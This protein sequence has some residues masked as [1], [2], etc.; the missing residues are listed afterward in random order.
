MIRTGKLS[1]SLRTTAAALL[2]VACS[3][4]APASGPGRA[5]DDRAQPRV[6]AD[7]SLADQ[8]ASLAERGKFGELAR[9][10]EGLPQTPE[11]KSL[12][13]SIALY[14]EHLQ[15][16]REAKQ[17]AYDEAL[18]EAMTHLDE[19]KV[20]DAMAKVIEAHSLSD[21]PDKL[22]EKPR[23][24]ELIRAVVAKAEKAHEE[25]RF[26]DSV[27]LYRLL[28]LLYEDSRK[29]HQEYLDAVTH[30][31]VLQLY[32]PAGLRELYKERAERL[33]D[34]DTLELFAEADDQELEDWT[35][36][37]EGIELTMI[38]QVFTQAATRHI[39]KD[40]Y[41]T[42]LRGAADGLSMMIQT[43][44]IESVFPGLKDE[45][46]VDKLQAKLDEVIED[47]DRPGR[48]L[49]RTS[50]MTTLVEIMEVNR[51]SVGLPENVIVYELTT[52]ATNQLDQFSAVIWPEELRQFTRSI[53]GNF[54]GVGVQIQK[55]DGK[56]TVVTPL[57]G[58]PA[59]KAGLKANDIIAR[60]NG[61]A[62]G[63]WSIDKAV[64]EITGPENTK[65]TLTIIREG[66]ED[67]FNVEITRK[68]IDLE[69]IKG[70]AHRDEGGW[71]YWVDKQAGIGYIRMTQFLRQ[72]ADDMDKAV[73]QMQKE[74]DLN[75]IVLDLRFNPG[76]LLSTAIGVVDRFIDDGRIVATVNAEG[77]A[78]SSH[79]ASRNKT[80]DADIDLVI[81]INQGSASASEIVSG[82]LQDYE[83]AIVLGENTYGKGSVQDIFPIGNNEAFFK[84]TTQYYQLPKGR[85]IH[86]KDDSK[87]WGIQ[88]DLE[89][90]MTNQE[91][92]DWLEA[93]RDADV[94]I[95]KEDRDPD[96]PQVNPRE[97][98]EQGL[99]PQLE[100]AVLLLKARQ[101]A[102]KTELA[103]RG[104]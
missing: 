48:R 60:V 30:V 49:T 69:S 81:L 27:S 18:A 59:M 68:Q 96:N 56:L 32:D 17:K 54:V 12:T 20:E 57:E 66:V 97:S 16:R 103:R 4:T 73:A 34:E 26:V 104:E 39:D 42:L 82:A 38:A 85:I 52:G 92:I 87:E 62:T 45:T 95:A 24:A 89:V 47:L 19:G 22:L 75:G 86:R 44:G 76:G 78:T 33:G 5:A 79:G 46:K 77:I 55:T 21:H 61:V 84:C 40:G 90:K 102:S 58:T 28:D 36:K 37:L 15:A 98:F 100:A 101:V 91:V 41:A 70:F 64:R 23:V 2:L 94:L 83:R 9:V 10:V 80:Y 50:A 29:Y 53:S 51:T 14:Q 74:G 8:I 72:T 43:D 65:V 25:A 1:L 99:D 31:R 63:G 7:A 67:P 88:P 11:S 6:A 13:R 35:I 93:R 3:S 71:D